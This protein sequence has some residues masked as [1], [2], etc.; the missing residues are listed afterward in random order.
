MVYCCHKLLK[1][2]DK[3]Y[4]GKMINELEFT[5]KNLTTNAGVLLLV[6]Y[7]SEEGIFK[8]LDDTLNF[9]NKHTEEI[10]MNHLKTLICG[11]FIGIDRLERF[12][13]IR[14]D[15]LLKEC[16]I[17]VRTPENISRFLG[18]FTFATTQL[19]RDASFKIFRN[20]LLKSKLSQI[21]IDIDSRAENVE[22]NHEGAVKGY[23][24]GFIGNKCYNVLYAFCDELKSYV[25]GFRRMGN[26]N[27]S[28]G[29]AE[30]IKE[31]VANLKDVVKDIVFRMDS[32]Y[33][34]EEIIEVIE[35]AGYHYVIKAK[36]Y[37]SLISK[38]Y[39]IDKLEWTKDDL[40]ERDKRE[41]CNV[42][43][44]LDTW[45]K[46][47]TFVITRIL[48]PFDERKQESLFEEDKYEHM[49]FTKNIELES[50][51]LVQYYGKR[52]NSENYIKETK[53]D[54]NIGKLKMQSFWANEAFFQ[55]MMVVYNIFLL[56][57]FD[58]VSKQEYR[59]QI[60]TFR[61]KYIYLAG[62]II[63]TGKKIKLKLL[64]SY[65]YKELFIRCFYYR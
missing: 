34:S 44:K 32:G 20:L 35:K 60:N 57:K 62:K 55:L 17:N 26:A 36:N 43:I 1:T 2:I 50:R 39:S 28:N 38:V 52:G 7:T 42:S 9:E 24:P 59:Q 6:N 49:L 41:Y 31:I 53:Y 14:N 4:F 47:R 63:S 15:R 22:G 5:E 37:A 21:T 19:L 58:K 16:G 18:N 29:A 12:L 13:L 54:M 25:S 3:R 51:K 45:S 56:F 23:N 46:E 65:P 30:L 8:I 33:F 27:T 64:N 61:L 11:G 10:K 40:S 48:K